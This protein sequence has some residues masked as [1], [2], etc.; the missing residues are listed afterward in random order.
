MASARPPPRWRSPAGS[1][2]A[3]RPAGPAP[4]W[5]GRARSAA[6]RVA[7]DRRSPP[8]PA[9]RASTCVAVMQSGA[10]VTFDPAAPAAST[11]VAIDTVPPTG[12]ACVSTSE[13]V[14]VD[15]SG[16]AVTFNPANPSA[17]A[18]A[19]VDPDRSLT[20]VTCVPGRP[21]V[22]RGRCQRL[23]G[24]VCSRRAGRAG[25]DG[26]SDRHRAAARR[27][28]LPRSDRLRRRRFGRQGVDALTR[29]R[30]PVQARS[31]RST[32]RANQLTAVTCP[33]S[34]PVP[35]LRQRRPGD[36]HQPAGRRRLRRRRGRRRTRA[37]GILTATCPA[38]PV[39]RRRQRR[40]RGQLHPR[41]V[42]DSSSAIDPAK[43]LAGIA[44]PS[45]CVAGDGHRPHPQLR[46]VRGRAPR[47]P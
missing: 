44:C 46:P 15:G 32:R 4:R 10:A 25:P 29:R 42:V 9:R 7:R 13:C 38:R 47:A 33:S 34:H 26:R 19:A 1:S 24:G 31:R 22:R 35:G 28:Q 37:T 20:A 17:A 11:P 5:R 23:R 39:R 2:C 27:R 16:N 21:P 6:T 18:T 3:F 30:R 41:P 40:Q 8:S 14:A 43:D 45:H 12:L 36:E